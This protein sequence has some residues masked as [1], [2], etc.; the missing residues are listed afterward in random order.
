[1]PH[2]DRRTFL[3]AAGAAAPPPRR[4]TPVAPRRR[5]PGQ[6]DRGE[7][8]SSAGA[9]FAV[10]AGERGGVKE[11]RPEEAIRGT[12]VTTAPFSALSG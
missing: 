7:A 5:G 8:S 9:D 1:M 12:R 10:G 6:A 2:I 3:A 11:E 4:R